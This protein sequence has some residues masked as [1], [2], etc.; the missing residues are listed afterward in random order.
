MVLRQQKTPFS[1][2]DLRLLRIFQ[3]VVRHE[4]FAAAQDELGI[5]PGTISNHITQLEARFGVR[6]CERGRRG[7]SVTDEGLRILEAAE[8]LLRSIENFSGIISSVRGVLSGTVHFGTVDAM[9]TN[10]D[11]QLHNAMAK[12]NERA[13]GVQIHLE[14]ASPQD[15]QQRLL[16]GR[17]SLIL[18]PIDDAHPSV[19]A[20]RLFEERQSLFCGTQHKLFTSHDGSLTPE[21]LQQFPYAARTYMKDN[22]GP[23]NFPF[24]NAAQASHMESLAILIMSGRYIGFLP[25]H[26]AA[27]FVSRGEMKSLLPNVTSYFDTFYLAHRRDERSRAMNL[28]FECL[29]SNIVVQQ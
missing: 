10:K 9:Y 28:L 2:T 1:P 16:D 29:R 23:A 12:F 14:I 22:A 26:F 8:N 24:R 17:Y 7:F 3:A 6:L 21:E 15:L 25:D 20:I 4:G 27:P 11:L 18:T 13:P 5:S 19:R